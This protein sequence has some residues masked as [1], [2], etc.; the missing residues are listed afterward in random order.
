MIEIEQ[1]EMRL[2]SMAV[3]LQNHG[4]REIPIT[5]LK[6]EVS[7]TVED[8]AMF[9]STARGSWYENGDDPKLRVREVH[10]PYDIEGKIKGAVVTIHRGLDDEKSN[11]RLAGCDVDDFKLDPKDGGAVVW[12]CKVSCF[13]GDSQLAHLYR[14]QRREFEISIQQAQAEMPLDQK[15]EPEPKARGPRKG[16]KEVKEGAAELH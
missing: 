7:L 1:A 9:S 15:D 10:G 2:A 4:D 16:A 13:P 6:I 11:I 14:G 3:N 12:S 5:Y 8:L